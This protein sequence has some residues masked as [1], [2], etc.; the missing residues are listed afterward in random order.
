MSRVVGGTCGGV[1]HFHC[2]GACVC[3]KFQR[4]EQVKLNWGFPDMEK[5]GMQL[6]LRKL[7]NVVTGPVTKEVESIK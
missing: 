5:N 6:D 1:Y 3:R 7:T 4:M 2:G